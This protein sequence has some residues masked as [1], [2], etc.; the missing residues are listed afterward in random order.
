MRRRVVL[1]GIG[2]IS[3]LGLDRASTW[4]GLVAGRSGIAPITRFDA[5]AYSCRFAGEVRGFDV[6]KYV[7][8]L[9]A[10]KELVRFSDHTAT[11]LPA[12]QAKIERDRIAGIAWSEA[13]YERGIGSAA[14]AVFDFAGSP[15]GAINVSGPVGAFTAEGRRAL[16]ERKIRAAGG[17]ISRRLGWISAELPKPA[18]ARAL[19]TG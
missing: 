8:R 17:E 10:G 18:T 5:A 15:L 16:I 9:Y 4:E 11:S 19:V 3:P 6:E 2:L 1:T 14:V 13:H 7:E 12:L